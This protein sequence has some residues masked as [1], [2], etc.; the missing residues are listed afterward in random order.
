MLM[1]K[2]HGAAHVLPFLLPCL[3]ATVLPATPQDDTGTDT[4]Q[5]QTWWNNWRGPNATAIA[6][7]GNPPTEWSEDK[8]IRWKMAIPG[9]GASSPI[10][11]KDHVYVTSAIQTDTDGEPPTASGGG[12]GRGGRG[13]G[14]SMG[15]PPPTKVY[16]FVV[17]ALNRKDGKI[18]WQTTVKKA[19][20][21]EAGHQHATQASNSPITDGERI[22]AH[23][24]SRGIHCLDMAGKV[25]WSKD[26]GIMQTALGFGEGSS[27]ALHGNTLLV[28]WDHQGRSFVIALNKHDGEELWRKDRNE[29]TT[30]ATP[31]IVPVD[32]RHQAI[33]PGARA[34]RAY[35]L[36]TGD[37]VWSCSG[38]TGN[39]IPTPIYDDGVVYLMTGF[40]GSSLQAIKLSGAKGDLRDSEHVVWWHR[41]NTP[42][43]PTGLVYKGYLYFL[44]VNSG[45]LSC[46][47]AKT[48][49]A[50][51][52]GQRLK[53]MRTT[54]SSIVGVADRIYITS[55]RAKTTVVKIGP[56]YER[57][58]LNNLDDVIDATVAIAG[59]EL[60]M[61]GRRYL[62]CIA[63]Q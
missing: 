61:R 31:L 12:G 6:P 16:E 58:A 14:F 60:Y 40:R 10:V 22:Y 36:E 21:H 63:K 34:S 33:L 23:F 20:P 53:R 37:L 46:L 52:E 59:D 42:Y 7:T 54:Y 3:T 50:H 32:G 19:V 41:K 55:R 5:I 27:P 38:L 8:N 49:K 9:V 15:G 57:L 17:I 48:G 25:L 1:K 47:D 62:Y 35:D 51:Y 13:G 29:G 43:A 45:V 28:T 24:G 11:W 2:T 18:A 56:K 4:R 30:W 39:P 26:L 44:R